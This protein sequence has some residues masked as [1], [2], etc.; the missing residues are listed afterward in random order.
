MDYST[1]LLL[2]KEG[3]YMLPI[4]EA[5]PKH[6]VTCYDEEKFLLSIQVGRINSQSSILAENN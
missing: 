1:Y 6:A 4:L 2:I 3:H 5:S